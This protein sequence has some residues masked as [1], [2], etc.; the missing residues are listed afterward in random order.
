MS[1]SRDTKPESSN[2]A[3]L[4]PE[5]SPGSASHV[6]PS[7]GKVETIKVRRGIWRTYDA[8]HGL[9][10]LPSCLLQDRQGYIWIGTTGGLCRYDGTEFITCTTGHRLFDKDI[11]MLYED[12][13]GRLWIGTGVWYQAKAVGVLCFDGKRFINYTTADG[14]PDNRVNAFCG[15]RQGRLWIATPRGL[16][17]FDGKKFVN[18][19]TA[20]GLADDQVVALCAGSQGRLWIGTPKGFSCFDGQQFMTY[21]TDVV[22]RPGRIMCE[23]SHGQLWIGSGF[24]G[25]GVSCF[26]GK[27]FKT[28]T[29]KDGLAGYQNRVMVVY[30]DH[31]GRMWFGELGGVSCFDGSG[32]TKYTIED[33]LLTSDV[34]DIIEDREGQFWF[35]HAECGLSCFEP[36]TVSLLTEMPP[37]LISTQDEDGHLWFGG[38]RGLLGLRLEPG[39]SDV[40]QRKFQFDSAV[41]SLM[42]DSKNR[43]WIGTDKH[44]LYRYESGDA[45]WKVTSGATLSEP[46][47]FRMADDSNENPVSALLEAKDG[48]IWVGIGSKGLLCRFDPNAYMELLESIDT[49]H[50]AIECLLEDSQG[51]LWL[52]GGS[53]GLSCWDGRKLTTYTQAD[54]LPSDIISSLVEDDASRIWVGTDHGLCCFDGKLFTIY[55]EEYGLRD[56]YHWHSCRDASGQ[57]WFATHGGI[58]RT[59]GEHFQWLTEADGLP[60]NYVAGLLPQP[61]GSMI[62]CAVHGV[63]RYQPTIRNP[64]RVEIREVI[65][66]K[67]YQNPKELKLTTKEAD[68][69]TIYYHSLSLATRRM[70]YSYML[71]GCDEK[72]KE[73]W[74]SQVRY[75][76]LPVGEYTFKV[77][78]IN[79][80]LVTSES[81]AILKLKVVP[82]PRDLMVSELQSDLR[83]REQQLAFLQREMGRK[84]QFE[85]IVGKSEAIEWVRSMMDRAIDS[86]LNVLIT[87]ETGTGK[88]LVANGIHLNSSRKDKPLIPFNCGAISKELVGSELFGHRKGSFTGAIEDKMGLFE[89][90]NG[91]TVVLDEIGDMPL[92]VQS[93]LLRIL[94]QRKVQRLGEFTLRDVDVRVIAMTNRPL[95]KEVREGRFRE[96]LYYRLNRFNIYIPPLRDRKDDIPLLAEHFYQ[97]ACRDLG[98]EL[99]GFAPGVMDMLGSYLWPGNVRELRNEVHR[100]C[101]LAQEGLPIQVYHFS[102]QITQ[103]ESL[104]QEVISE[105]L[106]YGKSL[107]Q[108][109]RRLVE[110]ALRQTDGNRTQAAKRLGMDAANLR[111]LIRTLGIKA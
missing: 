86:G 103:G 10:G 75:E 96:D 5:Q 31:H 47:H 83:V 24:A 4:R 81:P 33:G 89:V 42:V 43:L 39:L 70:R 35:A 85:T 18:Y 51:K 12:D 52:G 63:V 36:E 13:Q 66:D 95:L 26:D 88:E 57:L 23:D 77:I 65:A 78:A 62:I 40:Q 101:V 105:Q 54:G 22:P 25:K 8:T 94:E 48:T 41:L 34:V 21:T 61:D 98:K 64:P 49:P 84:Y 73:T 45:A 37:S 29:F 111:R 68:L 109:R 7:P 99:D 44:G 60:G 72:W 20:D 67:V 92:D 32:F 53:G 38:G 27:R 30:G 102:S 100:A 1:K 107:D 79:R 55:G 11:Q 17:C 69:F 50:G 90:A 15:D 56:L 108:F 76:N 6:S 58:Y 19:T 91:G 16:S 2:P 46:D 71:E 93:N 3:E 28:Y 9:P 14:L 87:G 82:D 106:S 104:M 74:D 97:E 59:D 80:D 110:E